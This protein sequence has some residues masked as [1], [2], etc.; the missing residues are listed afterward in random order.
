MFKK[1]ALSKVQ[2]LSHARQKTNK[3]TI[4]HEINSSDT[5][6]RKKFEN[7]HEHWVTDPSSQSQLYTQLKEYLDV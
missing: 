2:F 7:D 3:Q 4:A 5:E 6:T 1:E